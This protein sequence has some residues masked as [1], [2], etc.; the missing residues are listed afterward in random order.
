[1]SK[2]FSDILDNHYELSERKRKSSEQLIKVKKKFE[3]NRFIY[4]EKEVCIYCAGSL[5]RKEIGKHSDLDIFIVARKNISRLDE[6]EILANV[7]TNNRVLGYERISNNGQYLKVYSLEDMLRTVG[8]SQDDSE[9]L[10]TARMLLLL[11]SQNILNEE[12]YTEYLSSII[13][14]Y[15]RDKRGKRTFKPLFLLNDILR[16]WRTLCL[17]YELVRDD[18][19]RPWRKKNVNLKFS[20]MLTI[21]GTVL[22]LIARPV[23]DASEVDE[24]IRFSPHQRF[25][26][27]L[28]MLENL[29]L[30][31]DYKDFL[32]N[33]EKFLSW[34]EEMG[35]SNKTPSAELDEQSRIAAKQVSY[36]MYTVLSHE[37]IE[38][39]LRKYLII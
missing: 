29:G 12:L 13:N 5:G 25:A 20:R 24:I 35:I 32:D 30:E 26:I 34:R 4:D 38:R 23:S 3:E 16:F 19:K 11:E 15:F 6:L 36:F 37:K 14:H 9:N 2:Y 7:I 8:S 33:Y 28:D 18:P 1:M 17:N 39:D 10:F 21:F 27:G 22:P 31:K